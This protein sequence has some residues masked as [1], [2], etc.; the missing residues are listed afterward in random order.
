MSTDYGRDPISTRVIEAVARARGVDFTELP[1][2]YEA[3]DT[4]A[5]DALFVSRSTDAADVG[6]RLQFSYAECEVVVRSIEDI[7]VRWGAV[8]PEPAVSN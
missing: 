4:D 3:V 5:L 6:L 8:E 7:E 2:L 1:P